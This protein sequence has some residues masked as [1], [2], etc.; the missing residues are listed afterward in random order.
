MKTL[1][2]RKISVVVIILQLVVSVLFCVYV[3]MTGLIPVKYMVPLVAV[4]VLLLVY[5][6]MS[7]MTNSSYIF[8]RVLALVFCMIFLVGANYVRESMAALQNVGGATKKVDVIS[9]YVLKDDKAKTLGDAKDYTFGILQTQDRD[10]TDK[11][12][13]EAQKK[14][15]KTLKTDEFEDPLTMVDA[16]YTK[17][18]QV[19]ILNKSF[20]EIIKDKYSTFI[21]DTREL[22]AS[23][24]ETEVEEEIIDTDVTTKPFNVYISGIDLYGK[25]D[26]TSRSDV[27]IIATI[28]PLTK[29]V[30]LTSTPRDY[31]VPLYTKGGKSYSGGMPDKLTHA[32]NYGVDCSKNTL[33]KLYGVDIDYYVRVNFSSLKKIVNLLGGVKV[34]SD[35]DFISDWGPNG[36]GTHYKFKKGYN[37]VNGKKALAF[38][39]ERHH[40]ANGDY[41][42]GRNHQ[43]MIEAI[44]NKVMSPSV[45]P[46]FSKLLKESKS[47]FQTSMSKDRIVSLCNMQLNDM[48]KWKISYANAE[49]TGAKK[50]SFSIR[51]TPQY[52]CEPNYESV[53]K[54]TKRIKKVMKER[55]GE[56]DDSTDH[57]DKIE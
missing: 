2:K 29:K 54:I 55:P 17:E 48:A 20:V 47:M 53:R 35:Y 9:Y 36:A 42:R 22:E 41:Q 49:G 56:E 16:L 15:N 32:G 1:G 37:K 19:I 51:S 14:V 27:N 50:T 21:K 6:V 8:G 34:Y 43:H 28:N 46:N 12:L 4:A 23:Q 26:Q 5:Q 39:R 30:L 52:V 38:C 40:F 13:A 25:I 45:L 31:Y 7:Q 57:N 18:V 10:N 33:A 24:I 3:G 44:L 11:T